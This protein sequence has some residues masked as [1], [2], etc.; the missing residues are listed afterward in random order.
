M[1]KFLTSVIVFVIASVSILFVSF[2]SVQLENLLVGATNSKASTIPP[3]IFQFYLE[4]F[5]H[6][7]QN[8]RV[9]D[10][11]TPVQFLV[12][13]YS[14]ENNNHQKTLL[15][16]DRFIQKGVDINATM[17]NKNGLTAVHMAVLLSS[18]TLLGELIKRKADVNR[19]AGGTTE[20][21][22]MTPLKF[23]H[24]V[25]NPQTPENIATMENALR[26]AGAHE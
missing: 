21:T 6:I 23:F 12:F 1:K 14:M 19:P 4:N 11:L 24:S 20:I 18:P 7:D 17:N 26:D 3:E 10:G 13:S 15:L 22:G 9:Q 8:T 2:R 16:M 25:Q 5:A